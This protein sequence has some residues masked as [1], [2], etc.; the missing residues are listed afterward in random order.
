MA[1]PEAR[2]IW[3]MRDLLAIKYTSA[4]ISIVDKDSGEMLWQMMM[5]A[6]AAAAL[7]TLVGP[8]GVLA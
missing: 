4:Y 1:G 5:M 2:E 3:S 7:G 8:P 6:A